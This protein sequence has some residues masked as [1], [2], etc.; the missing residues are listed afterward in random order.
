M[1]APLPANTVIHQRY[2]IVRPIGQGGFG[3]VYEAVDQRLGATVALKQTIHRDPQRDAA[4]E[5]EARL[6][7]SLRH[8][9]L[10]R[11]SDYFTDDQGLFLVMEFI[12]GDDLL[13]LLQQRGAPFL[14]DEV[15]VWADQLLTAL[16]FLHTQEPPII[17]RD[18]K[19][20]NLKLTPRGE[21]ILLDFGL[22]RGRV[23]V[24]APPTA[25]NQSTTAAPGAAAPIPPG[26]GPATVRLDDDDASLRAFTPSYAAPEQIAGQSIDA[27]CD[28]YALAATLYH[29]LLGD[30]PASAQTRTAAVQQ[31]Q[32]DPLQPLV[33]CNPQVPAAI[34]A[35]VMQALALDANERPP[36]ALAMQALLHTAAT[37]YTLAHAPPAPV[38][39]AGRPFSPWRMAW[40]IALVLLLTG[41]PIWMASH[42]RPAPLMGGAVTP[43]DPTA[44]PTR[45]MMA[46][47]TAQAHPTPDNCQPMDG[48]F[49][50]A[51]A[52]FGRIDEPGTVVLWEERAQL[53]A[54]IADTIRTEL[55]KH[56]DLK[57]A[58]QVQHDCS[59]PVLATSDDDQYAALQRMADVAQADLVIYGT[60]EQHNQRESFTPRFYV[61][62]DGLY[63]A[64]ELIGMD[65]LG[66]PVTGSA[67]VFRDAIECR[68]EAITLFVT[69]LAYFR[70]AH[71]DSAVRLFERTTRL[72]CWEDTDGKEVAYLY[73]GSAY[74]ARGDEGDLDRALTSFLTATDLNPDYARPYI[75]QGH[76]Y[77]EQF[78]TTHEAE[79]LDQAI[80]AYT[81]ALD[82]S[83]QPDTVPIQAKVHL[84]LGNVY[85]TR[86][87][88]TDTPD[89][90]QW[91]S[92]AEIEYQ[93]VLEDYTSH[94]DN[95]LL[96]ELA[97]ATYCSLS[98]LHTMQG[99]GEQARA[100][101]SDSRALSRE[102][103]IVC[104]VELPTGS[105][106]AVPRPTTTPRPTSEAHEL[107][108][109]QGVRVDYLYTMRIAADDTGPY[110]RMRTTADVASERSGYLRNGDTVTI[111]RTDVDGW[112]EIRIES[113]TDPEQ[114]GVVGW[115]ERWL[116]DNEGVP[117]PPPPTPTAVPAPPQPQPA[118]PP[119]PQP[120]PPPPPVPLPAMPTPDF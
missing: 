6:L 114:R 86:A 31:A 102:S 84:S 118:P 111:V 101:L 55:E 19:P 20:Q 87:Y 89:P 15:L 74:L 90:A 3:A 112:Y 94:P 64:E 119:Q 33:Q 49:N 107:V 96:Q 27:R 43:A 99:D 51:I 40:V 17:H 109:V 14:V 1:T 56:A 24:P 42:A 71:H 25:H 75:G 26:A 98:L 60:Y 120:Q 30:R 93:Q 97:A 117:A 4:F 77:Y 50:I 62:G 10:P 82:A 91:F 115:I 65:Q 28:L 66:A 37:A 79:L 13:N 69:G 16:N 110:T 52:R 72:D 58:I 8:L 18:I 88:L 44:E 103:N 54:S 108:T 85:L 12:P 45:P 113:S 68:T 76:V 9:A 61:R 46:A 22:A 34:S 83:F 80:G 2:R 78:R 41:L 59:G 32:P 53:S 116:V 105:P 106:T 38:Q 36:T 57:A 63:Q 100:A 104:A 7:A 70:A 29:L 5:R 48:L 47:A 67:M 92:L 23:P 35:V 73:L 95:Q 11:V 81:R 21:I 39:T